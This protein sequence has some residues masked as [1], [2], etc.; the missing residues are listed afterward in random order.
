MASQPNIGTRRG[1]PA[2]IRPEAAEPSPGPGKKRK[3][4]LPNLPGFTAPSITPTHQAGPYFEGGSLVIYDNGKGD[5]RRVTI[6]TDQDGVI[7]HLTVVVGSSSSE[8]TAKMT[9]QQ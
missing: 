3:P 9:P 5:D 7:R 6:T 1:S 8:I 2:R 4:I